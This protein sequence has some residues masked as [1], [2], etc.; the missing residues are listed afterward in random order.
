MSP[1]RTVLTAASLALALSACE[2][3]TSVAVDVQPQF[4]AS[5]K[6]CR[7]QIVSLIASTWPWAHN[8]KVAF[9]PSPGA[10]PK[11]LEEFGPAIGI[12][13]VRELQDFFCS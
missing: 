11:W 1:A 12:S 9:P 4:A 6:A 8:D 10:I 13:T 5:A 3:P 2:Q 7:G